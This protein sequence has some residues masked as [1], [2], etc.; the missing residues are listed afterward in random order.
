VISTSKLADIAFQVVDINNSIVSYQHSKL[1]ISL[2]WTT[3]TD[4]T[5]S[6]SWY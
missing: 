5:N 3:G 2:I 6:H 1:V 4:I